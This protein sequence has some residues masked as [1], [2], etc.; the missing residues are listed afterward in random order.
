M[1]KID[2]TICD[3]ILNNITTMKKKNLTIVETFVG[4]GGS[5][6]GFSRA[7]FKTLFVNDVNPEMINTIKLNFELT[8]SDYHIGNIQDVSKEMIIKKKKLENINVDV[9]CGGIVCKGFSLAGVRNPSDLRNYLYLEQLRLVKELNPKISVIENVPQFKT[10]K[11]IRETTENKLAIEKLRE[12]YDRKKINNGQKTSQNNNIQELDDEYKMICQEIKEMENL[13]KNSLY[14][15]F[16]HILQL[17]VDLGYVVYHKILTCADY[18]D[19]THRKRLFIVAIRN[20]VHTQSGEFL[21]PKPTHKNPSIKGE[22]PNWKT[23]EDCFKQIDENGIN[24]PDVDIDNRPMNH[25]QKTI[26]RFSYIPKGGSL[27]DVKDTIPIELQT[28]KI[29]S[30]RGSCKRLDDKK[31]C[32]TLVPGH[33]AFPVHP[34]KN[35]S[36]TIREGACLT[37]FPN[38]YKFS[39]SHTKRCEQIGNA[40]PIHTAFHLASSIHSYL[41]HLG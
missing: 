6:L 1:F 12:L 9:L 5:H 26:H 25:S 8:L 41:T 35:R 22:L 34:T 16:E 27:M 33:S 15:V 39:G 11:I 10:T 20:D 4:C 40:I 31:S 17:Y 19:Y 28:N 7:G 3:S 14:S 24:H 23:V 21:F 37:G 13:L 2:L 18:G 32:P 29:F 30:S 36:I 38:N